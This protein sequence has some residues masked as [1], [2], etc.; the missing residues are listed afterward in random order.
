MVTSSAWS[1]GLGKFIGNASVS[2]KYRNLGEA[3]L[4]GANGEKYYVT[5]GR[6]PHLELVRRNEIPAKIEKH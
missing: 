3:I 4:F 1:W 6:E 2:S 5:L